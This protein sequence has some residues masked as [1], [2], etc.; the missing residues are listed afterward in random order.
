MDVDPN[1]LSASKH[2]DLK[3]RL[4][5]TTA[6]VTRI[7]CAFGRVLAHLHM[8]GL[9]ISSNLDVKVRLAAGWFAACTDTLKPS[10][11]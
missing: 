10:K 3:G 6:V 11:N 4:K 5:H 7:A 2:S 9:V 8:F 1:K